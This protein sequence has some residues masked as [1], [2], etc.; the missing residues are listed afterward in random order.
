MLRAASLALLLV[1]PACAEQASEAEQAQETSNP[2]LA[3]AI[4]ADWRQEDRAR[5]QYRNPY[6]TLSFFQV[7]PGMTVVDYAPGNWYARVLVPYLG[8]DG[9]YIG[10]TGVYEQASP[11]RLASQKIFPEAF[12]QQINQLVRDA[13]V[14]GGAPAAFTHGPSHAVK[15][16]ARRHLLSDG[17]T[18]RRRARRHARP[19]GREN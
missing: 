17:R 9:K 1:S 14:E 19:A 15:P 11:T 4:A 13:G 6:E 2:A 5:D 8:A 18:H 16:R 10:A 3:A 7:E 12:P